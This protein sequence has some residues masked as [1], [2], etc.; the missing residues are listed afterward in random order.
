MSPRSLKAAVAAAAMLAALS[1]SPALAASGDSN[2]STPVI[3]V[4]GY[5]PF[6]TGDNCNMWSNMTSFLK[7]N[8]KFTGPLVTLKYYYNDSNCGVD[9]NNF[10]SQSTY[11]P[12]GLVNGE[13]SQNTDIRHIAYQF[14][15]Y[16]YNTYSSKG[17]NVGIVAHS[18]G[19]LIVRSALYRVAAGDP[20][21]PPDLLVSNIVTYGTPHDG[22]NSAQI[23]GSS[24]TQCS[25]MSPGSS[26]LSDL[27][28]NGQNP[29]AQGGT[30]WTIIGSDADSIVS[31][32]SA[33]FMTA[34]HKVQ[35]ASSDNI[36]HLNYYNDTQTTLNAALKSSDFGG[37]YV[38][39]T[40]GE[41]PVLRAQ[42]ALLGS[43]F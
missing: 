23:C 40:T 1:A 39:T 35:Y 3:F 2:Q 32:A 31:D 13:D 42:K 26:Y 10:G 27:N 36:N 8:G 37:A 17:Q 21:F 28:S 29:Q 24:T 33:T 34:N 6:G 20:N 18:M 41:W 25:E 16:V 9:V 5:D 7:S 12:G 43:G 11:F 30:D 22:T 4:H 38:S 14:A 15:W 19:G